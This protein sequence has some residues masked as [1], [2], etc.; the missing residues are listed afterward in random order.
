MIDYF[1]AIERLCK[2]KKKLTRKIS[3]WASKFTGSETL[4]AARL[5]RSQEM[6][7]EYQKYVKEVPEEARYPD[8]PDEVK[9]A[10]GDIISYIT[11]T[12]VE[13][14]PQYRMIVLKSWST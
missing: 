4:L 9:V 10:L 6:F 5:Q 13:A 2:E 8:I 7:A 12:T 3:I 1:N 14:I 11:G